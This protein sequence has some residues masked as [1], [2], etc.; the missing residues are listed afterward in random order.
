MYFCILKYCYLSLNYPFYSF[1]SGALFNCISGV[2]LSQE[3]QLEKSSW[4]KDHHRAMENLR[5][6]HKRELDVR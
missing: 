2:K 5:K 3:K 6:E 1:L 4:N